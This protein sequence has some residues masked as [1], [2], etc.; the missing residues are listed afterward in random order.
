MWGVSVEMIYLIQLLE[1]GQKTQHDKLLN[2]TMNKDPMF[3][4]LGVVS[5][6]STQS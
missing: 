4:L 3:F 5:G 1:L 2:C 6:D